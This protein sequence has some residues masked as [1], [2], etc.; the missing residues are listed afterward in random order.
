[1][2]I[3]PS[4]RLNLVE[5]SSKPCTGACTGYAT[6]SSCPPLIVLAVLAADPA[7]ATSALQLPR[8]CRRPLGAAR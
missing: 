3:A 1:M 2:Q 4:T 5:K 6:S 8:N 7:A